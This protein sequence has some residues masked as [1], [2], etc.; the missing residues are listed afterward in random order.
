MLDRIRG[1]R[2]SQPVLGLVFGFCFG[3]LLQKGGVCRYEII[4]RQLLLEDFTVLKIIFTAVITGM[5][6]VYAM[7][8][9]GW[10]TLHKKPGSLGASVPGPLVFG[11]GFGLLGYCPGT[12]V[13]AVGHGALD[14]LV[15]GVVGIMT[16]AGLYAAAFPWLRE[17]ILDV[18]DFGDRTLIDVLRPRSSWMVIAP[19]VTIIIAGLWV[20]ERS[21]L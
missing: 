6:G 15:G 8:G 18:G 21:G 13:G 16:G 10:V 17:R 1:S 7:R 11:V 3:F 9:A 12:A 5:V 19:T 14:A 2:R 4:M 20:L